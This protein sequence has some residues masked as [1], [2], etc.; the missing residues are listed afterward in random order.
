MYRTIAVVLISM[1]FAASGFVQS[2][3]EALALSKDGKPVR[4][5]RG[6]RDSCTAANGLR[7]RRHVARGK[8]EGLKMCGCVQLKEIKEVRAL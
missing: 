4:N 8:R 7:R 5:Q 2:A 1:S 6:A 3:C